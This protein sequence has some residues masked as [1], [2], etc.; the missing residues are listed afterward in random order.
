MGKLM[1][2]PDHS[3]AAARTLEGL[4]SKRYRQATLAY[5]VADKVEDLPEWLQPV[6]QSKLVALRAGL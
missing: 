6:F 4:G 2:E 1:Q 5:A 3:R